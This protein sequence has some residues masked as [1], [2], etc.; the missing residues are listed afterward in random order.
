MGDFDTFF[1]ETVESKCGIPLEKNSYSNLGPLT[2]QETF[3]E[4]QFDWG[5]HLLKGNGGAQRFSQIE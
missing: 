3:S 5:G 1:S 4:G 2:G